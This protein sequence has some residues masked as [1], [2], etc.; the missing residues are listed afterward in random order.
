M[1]ESQLLTVSSE[2]QCSGSVGGYYISKAFLDVQV[3]QGAAG[4]PPA[5]N[6]D[7]KAKGDRSRGYCLDFLASSTS[8]DTFV[9]ER[10]PDQ[11]LLT[12][13]TSK[14][15]D[16]SQTIALN[17]IQTVFSAV[18]GAPGSNFPGRSLEDVASG[19]TRLFGAEYDPFNR[20][21][22]ALVN[23]G[24]KDF[25][26]CLVL[27]GEEPDSRYRN[28]D[29]YCNS[30]TKYARRERALIAASA[31]TGPGSFVNYTKGILY[32]PRLPYNLFLFKKQ[33]VS[34]K[35]G[36]KWR[37]ERSQVAYLENKSPTLVIGVDRTYFASRSTTLNFT[38]GVLQDVE[39]DKDSEL[40]NFVQIPM[41]IAND[42]TKLPSQI[43]QVKIDQ[44]SRKANLIS[45][46]DQLIQEQKTLNADRV[47]LAG[48]GPPP[49]PPP[50]GGAGTANPPL[51]QQGG[52]G[53]QGG[54]S[55]CVSQCL[56]KGGSTIDSCQ[57][58]CTGSA[59]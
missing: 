31:Y 24:L 8:N 15:D 57:K 49:A 51:P 36:G 16:Q 22:V 45:A 46:Q 43:I 41:A 7:V 3:V 48:M 21:Q 6:V 55:S 23:D 13:I 9:V 42:V 40:K 54:T 50:G 58:T 52:A 25:G 14:A 19:S 18:S 37:L 30:P 47:A 59:N 5:V 2:N 34:R 17:I 56:G 12:K 11:N 39:V 44:S 20:D 38:M 28:I 1:A 35:G 10:D 4:S 53:Q 27:E 29:E 33:Q 32:K 26:F